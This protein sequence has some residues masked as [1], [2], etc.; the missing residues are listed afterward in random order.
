MA[1]EV[2]QKR[3]NWFNRFMIF[4]IAVVVAISLGL[5]IY[6]FLLDDETL[7]LS[8][9]SIMVNEGDTFTIEIVHEN[10]SDDT[11]YA[12]TWDTSILT[13]E[14]QNTAG[15][16]YEFTA[17]A[18]GSTKITLET[19]NPN[20]QD[21]E[22]SVNVGDGTATNP[23]YIKSAEDLAKIGVG[24]SSQIGYFSPS[25]YYTQLNSIDLASYNNGSWTPLCSANGFS[26][27]YDGA[28]YAIYNLNVR[29]SAENAGLFA[30]I[31]AGGVVTRIIFD[32]AQI[33]GAAI[34][35]GVVA[36]ISSG[37]IS[38]IEVVRSTVS[39][40]SPAGEV[41]VGGIVGKVERGADNTRVDR[42][43]F[44]EN[45]SIEVN[46]TLTAYV[47][48]LVGNN[49]SGTI[50]NSFSIGKLNATGDK[51]VAGGIAG[52]METDSSIEDI[53]TSKKANIINSYST[54]IVSASTKG[55]IVG[56]NINLDGSNAYTN[57]TQN[58]EN[59]YVG[60]Y[61][62]YDSSSTDRNI[63]WASTVDTASVVDGEFSLVNA[64]SVAEAQTQA[65]YKTYSAVGA[66]SNW[67]FAN[68]WQIS[69][70]TNNGLPTLQ[71][72]GIAVADNIYDPQSSYDGT[73][74]TE[75][76]L[77]LIENDLN[78]SY[79][80]GADFEIN[81]WTPIGT[82]ENPFNGTLDGQNH[83]I[84]LA[85]GLGGLFGYLGP[86]AQII[87]LN[88]IA[89]NVTSGTNVGIIASVNYGLINNCNVS[90]NITIS[91][92]EDK[93]IGAIVG[94]NGSSGQITN[95][96]A[97]NTGASASLVNIQVS[98]FESHTYSVGGIAGRNEGTISN[99][100]NYNN[101]QISANNP[102][103]T[104]YAGGIV[105]Q[106][107]SSGNV[108][109]VTN[110]GEISIS[111]E[112]SASTAGG[113]AGYNG[114][115]AVINLAKVQNSNISGYLVGGLVGENAGEDTNGFVSVRQSQ[116][117]DSTNLSGNR[118]GGL[119][120][121][122]YRGI[123]EN[124]ATYANLSAQTMAGFAV[125]VEGYTGSGGNGK[126]AIV[127]TCFS[128]ATFD[129]QAG[130]AYAETTSVIR[131]TN[132]Y[133]YCILRGEDGANPDSYKIAGYIKNCK[134]NRAGPDATGQGEDSYRQQGSNNFGPFKGSI[135]DGITSDEDCKRA[136]TFDGTRWLSSIWI[137]ADGQYPQI[138]FGN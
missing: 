68:V 45:S 40:S 108:N 122:M 39:S 78:G 49:I 6:Y 94:I 102:N 59:R 13:G 23:F 87:N 79:I 2:A 112:N 4:L 70:D 97:G 7:G 11:T 46:T 132:N 38:R 95:C 136:S 17:L 8:E 135:P 93:N 5:V 30:R 88:V 18:G 85:S 65:T 86:N 31:N 123:I 121:R 43:A 20:F 10:A 115:R 9:S 73:I 101:S 54:M 110:E 33:S 100:T 107:L 117:F 137:I 125:T 62:I 111:T 114:Y 82:E 14:A 104:L 103:G 71:M 56:M 35:A 28:G 22:C 109:N 16:I 69:S 3:T 134:Y 29:T 124:C 90:G 47:G 133:L 128:G 50:I 118:A 34:N 106:N 12:L 130:K 19:S 75:E 126:Y 91:G 119:V 44:Y 25:A 64:V 127:Q 129:G 83:T 92:Q 60:V 84:T 41:N 1:N 61:Y 24:D 76:Q 99:V 51:V 21:M 52:K 63:Y 26:G 57:Q 27:N 96:T 67:D 32:N 116:V 131:G 98:N 81:D 113:I 120:G 74:Q 36:G 66:E 80:I 48:G 138:N 77:K 15:T 72:M 105:G 89:E 53:T 58:N 55:A 37:T 42:V